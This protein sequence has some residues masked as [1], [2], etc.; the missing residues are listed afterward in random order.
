MKGLRRHAELVAVV[1][2]LA[3]FGETALF[4][5]HTGAQNSPAPTLETE[6]VQVEARFDAL[7]GEALTQASQVYPGAPEAV[8]VLGRCCSSTRISR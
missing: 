7:G 6:I 8:V 4:D 2:T 3:I 5:R 1:V